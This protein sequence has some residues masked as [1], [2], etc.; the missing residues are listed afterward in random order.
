[1]VSLAL[2]EAAQVKHNTLSLVALP[3]K[4]LC[5]VLESIDFLGIALPLAL[6][7]F[8]DFLLEDE[9]F[10]SAVALLLGSGKAESETR[11]VVLLLLDKASEAAVL[12]LVSLDL[13]LEFLRLLGKLLDEGLELEEL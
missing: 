6:E 5:S 13:A 8:G 2:D 4:I 7:L 11:D 3:R 12:A 9:G 1:M 10:E